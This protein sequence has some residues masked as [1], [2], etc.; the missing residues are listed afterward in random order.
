MDSLMENQR[1][2]AMHKG[3]SWGRFINQFLGLSPK[4]GGTLLMGFKEVGVHWESF[5]PHVLVTQRSKE[6][7]FIYLL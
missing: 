3:R 4:S 2:K 1:W 7:F 5:L 6:I